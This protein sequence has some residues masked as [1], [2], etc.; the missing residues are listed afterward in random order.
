MKVIAISALMLSFSLS[1]TSFAAGF[2]SSSGSSSKNDEC[3]WWEDQGE[4]VYYVQTTY[5]RKRYGTSNPNRTISACVRGESFRGVDRYVEEALKYV[6]P[7]SGKTYNFCLFLDDDIDGDGWGDKHSRFSPPC[8]MAG[9]PISIEWKDPGNGN[10]FP[11]C[12]YSDSDPDGDGW[13]FEND[14]SCRMPKQSDLKREVLVPAVDVKQWCE[15]R[16]VSDYSSKRVKV[17]CD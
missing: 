12:N 13:G 7:E 5:Y 11:F 10:T 15:E 17:Y 16:L 2:F 4:E 8:K 3:F 14:A 9:G 1:A 6:D